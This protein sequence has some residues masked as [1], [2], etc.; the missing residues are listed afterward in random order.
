M[1]VQATNGCL[2]VSGLNVE[3]RCN[4]PTL[5]R[6]LRMC[7]RGHSR[8][9]SLATIKGRMIAQQ[10][11]PGAASQELDTDEPATQAPALVYKHATKHTTWL[12]LCKSLATIAVSPDRGEDA[13]RPLALQALGQLSRSC[14]SCEP[15]TPTA[16]SLLTQLQQDLLPLLRAYRYCSTLPGASPLWHVYFPM[17]VIT[18]A[19]FTESALCLDAEL[20]NALLTSLDS[21]GREAWL[22]EG[23]RKARECAP[24][25]ISLCCIT[26]HVT[27]ASS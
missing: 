16:A 2:V 4:L 27:V 9:C 20:L 7:T 3:T 15:A 19:C 17:I 23:C 11:E 1:S 12:Q 18:L 24:T 5:F 8:N 21:L 6:N 26:V 13:V 14:R 10:P 22:D 25:S